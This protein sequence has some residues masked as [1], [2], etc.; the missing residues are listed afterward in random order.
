MLVLGSADF[1]LD[2]FVCHQSLVLVK[3][4]KIYIL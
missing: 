2:Y 4:P 1:F 3:G